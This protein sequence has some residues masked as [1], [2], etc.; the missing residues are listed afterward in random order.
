MTE[1][2]VARDWFWSDLW[3]WLR[4]V[5]IGAPLIVS[6]C[7]QPD[8][9]VAEVGATAPADVRELP[10]IELSATVVQPAALEEQLATRRADRRWEK[11][12]P[13][14]EALMEPTESFVKYLLN[15]VGDEFQAHVADAGT[16]E[17]SPTSTSE[18]NHTHIHALKDMYRFWKQFHGGCGELKRVSSLEYKTSFAG[19]YV[20][21]TCF[22]ERG[23]RI[24]RLTFDEHDGKINGCQ[25]TDLPDSPT[26][27]PVVYPRTNAQCGY[28]FRF[29]ERISSLT[30]DVRVV[31][32]A[33]RPRRINCSF[34]IWMRAHPF[35]SGAVGDQPYLQDRE[36]YIWRRVNADT[37]YVK[38]DHDLNRYRIQGLQPGTYRVAARV[39]GCPGSLL[40]PEL[41]LDG[42]QQETKVVMPLR[43]A[44]SIE[45]V[46]HDAASTA[47]LDGNDLQLFLGGWSWR[48][49]RVDLWNGSQSPWST[50]RYRADELHF[51]D[52]RFSLGKIPAGEYLLG[53]NPPVECRMFAATE[54]PKEI[55]FTVQAGINNKFVLSTDTVRRFV[56]WNFDMCVDVNNED[57]RDSRHVEELIQ[58]SRIMLLGFCDRREAQDVLYYLMRVS[59]PERHRLAAA[60]SLLRH[61]DLQ[62]RILPRA[63]ETLA[64]VNAKEQPVEFAAPCVEI[65][66]RA[67]GGLTETSARA[68]S[69]DMPDDIRRLV[70]DLGSDFPALRV[71]ASRQLAAEGKRAS[72]A[73]PFLQAALSDDR[74]EWPLDDEQLIAFERVSDAAR[75]ALTA[76]AD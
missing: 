35:Y 19:D 71:H 74:L 6:G 76:I 54:P 17:I 15:D 61:D 38:V 75:Q 10:P 63:A 45:I 39:R 30:L 69:V 5:M 40:S 65:L 27:P 70:I 7:V 66:R 3:R 11:T 60:R 12:A 18:A 64:L 62:A 67:N 58:P 24:I 49:W 43:W 2:T 51:Q 50:S 25:L 44:N 23:T 32:D 37:Y 46:V 28:I 57:L 34:D 1:Y 21:A 33:D 73:I 48:A 4:F 26:Y 42:S 52:G 41:F 22:G 55:A 16:S 29:F 20:E 59:A 72:S 9:P 8:A 53:F 14:P 36:G 31:E 56:N 13:M 68:A 47:S